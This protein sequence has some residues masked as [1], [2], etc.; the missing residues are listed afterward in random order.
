MDDPVAAKEFYED[1]FGWDIVEGS[2]ESGGYM[3]ATKDGRPAA[4]IGP[5]PPDVGPMPCVWSSYFAADDIDATVAKAE[6]AGGRFMMPPFDV[7]DAG[8]M[9]F[10]MDSVGAVYGLWQAGAHKGVGIFNEPGALCWNELHTT[11]FEGSKAFYEAVFGYDYDDIG[12]SSMTYAVVRRPGEAEGMAGIYLD[13]RMPT[14]V[15]PHWQVWFAVDN[16][17]DAVSKAT[18]LG[19]TVLMPPMDSPFGRMSVIQAPQGEP[20]GVIDLNTKVGEPPTGQA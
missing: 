16:A 6:A 8:K 11:D 12:D 10:G 2:A 13:P 17:D 4:G 7:M 18:E 1:L 14:G 20:F 3:L 19:S 9:T 15:P 5:K